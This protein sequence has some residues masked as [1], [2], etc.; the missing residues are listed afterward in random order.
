MKKKTSSVLTYVWLTLYIIL[1]LTWGFLQSFVGLCLFLFFVNAPHDFYHGSIRTKW[2]SLKGVSLGLF[3]FTPDENDKT[4]QKKYQ[5]N[6]IYLENLCNRL[7]VHEYGHTYQ[8]LL[9]GP[10]YL[11][12]IGTVSWSWANLSRYK[13]LRK[14]YAVPYSFCWTESWANRL[15]EWVLG[16]PSITF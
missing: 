14:D 5:N 10:F 16:E 3:I 7:S 12:I 8:S 13:N 9:L 11:V 4:L 1:Q 15:G 2:P 6:Q